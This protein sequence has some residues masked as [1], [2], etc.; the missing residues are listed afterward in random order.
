[1]LQRLPS[2]GH[3]SRTNKKYKTNNMSEETNCPQTAPCTIGWSEVI[4][5]DK[6]ACI[7]FYTKLNGWTTEDMEFPDGM[8]YTMF[9]NGEQ[10]IAGC[11]VPPGEESAPPMWL[12][13][14]KTEDLDASA[15]KVKALGGQIIKER[16]DLPMGSFVIP[17]D[18]QGAATALWD[19]NDEYGL[20]PIPISEPTRP[21]L[22]SYAVLRLKNKTTHP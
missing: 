10:P 9:K 8:V 21:R 14:I 11:C 16:I 22:F 17:A 15:A 6:A 5:T 18:P 3:S 13:Y 2:K 12:N 1:M 4:T 7:E 20:S 19:C